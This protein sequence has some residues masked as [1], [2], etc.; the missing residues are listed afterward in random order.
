M[1]KISNER[2]IT[3]DATEIKR[4]SRDYCRQFY[5]NK[6]G[7]PEKQIFCNILSFMTES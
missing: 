7:N 1:R 3:T 6:L 2:N 5:I 4:L